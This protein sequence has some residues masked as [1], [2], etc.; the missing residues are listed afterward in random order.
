MRSDC[1]T[2]LSPQLSKLLLH[3]MHT[4]Y[5]SLVGR[6]L[7]GSSLNPCHPTRQERN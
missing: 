2:L 5:G 1:S 6:S 4:P 3:G 7:L